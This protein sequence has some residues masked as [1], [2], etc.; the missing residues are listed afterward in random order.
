MGHYRDAMWES[1]PQGPTRADRMG[2]VYRF[3]EADALAS[4]ELV[5]SADASRAC[6]RAAVALAKLDERARYSS[7]AE[8]LSDALLR[9]ES[10]SSSRIEGLEMNVRKLLELE[11]LEELGVAHRPHSPEAEVLGNINAMR[12]AVSLGARDGALRLDDICAMH[13]ALLRDTRLADQGGVLRTTQNWIGGSWYTPL[14][15]RY[16]PP[17]PELVVPLM[18][19]LVEFINSARLPVVAVA[20]L[21]HAQLE[22]I[23]PFVDGNGRTGRAL[24]HVVLRRGR[25]VERSV[26]PVSPVLLTLREQYYAGLESYRF[27]EGREP[28]TLAEAASTWVEFFCFA[29]ERA[30]ERADAF[31][32]SM[33]QLRVRW[34]ELVRARS[35]SATELLL[36][37]LPGNPVVSIASAVRL[38]GRSY[39]AARGAVRALEEAGVLYQ[40]SKN[41]KSGLYVAKDVIDEFTRYERALATVS[42]DTR[43]ERPVRRVPQRSQ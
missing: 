14:G 40:S 10:L 29:V 2:G 16:V 5:L 19:D 23:H 31:E 41:R 15:A 39:P 11:A 6:E 33:E 36:D 35:G 3:Y 12:E 26:V 27:D 24:V 30:C 1:D 17:R 34:G 13:A 18:E 43:Q 7:S 8:N 20:A 32:R 42:G 4:A 38:T 25:L 37:A 22:T 28:R 9:S 21:A